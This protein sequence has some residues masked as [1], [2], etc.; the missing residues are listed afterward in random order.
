M[1]SISAII[2]TSITILAYLT[3]YFY[4]SVNLP[5][6]DDLLLI[7]FVEF[8]SREAIGTTALVRDLFSAF[9]D[10]KPVIPRLIS[11]TEYLI[12]GHLNFRFYIVLIS[13]NI[14]FIFYFLYLQFE[15]TGLKFYYFLP[16]PFLFLQPLYH[17]VS[18]WAL[19]GLQ[20]T[21]VTVF[22]ILA[23]LLAS[24]RKKYSLLGSVICC[25]LATFTHGNGILTF[26]AM[27]FFY[28]CFQDFRKAIGMAT[29]MFVAVIT[30]LW[31]YE[32]GQANSVTLDITSLISYQL[33]FVGSSMAI[34][35]NATTP[36]IV[37][38]GITLLFMAYLV[39]KI[40]GN[41][42][43]KPFVLKPGTMELLSLF[44]FIFISGTVVAIFRSWTGITIASRFQLYASLSIV[45]FYILLLNYYPFFQKRFILY[46]IT[47]FS[48][49]YWG[50]SY[51]RYADVVARKR[52][53]YIADVY[54]WR[55]NRTL[56]SID[57]TLVHNVD[58]FLRDAY[59]SGIF[60]LPEPVTTK[61]Q[62]DS[63]F[64]A[65]RHT[66][67]K[68]DIYKEDWTFILPESRSKDDSL[69]Y[70]HLSSTSLPK[71]LGILEDRFLV[72]R[73]MA[74]DSIFLMAANPKKAARMQIIKSGSYY[75]HGF[76]A[77]VRNNDLSSGQYEL[78]LM[79]ISRQGIKK[80]NKLERAL[81]VSDGYLSLF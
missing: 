51:Y 5:Y 61:H 49:L 65:N 72:L 11:L 3:F 79:T 2:L 37:F 46:G 47:L 6:Q 35:N 39:F 33:G 4:F 52:T 8:F 9:N 27:L 19:T 20:H 81:N 1:K 60:R 40:A 25:F 53:T 41:Y 73:N 77:L 56:L 44:A 14:L 48:I 64:T 57:H 58:F 28:L 80:F 38:G 21:F 43:H 12:H 54:N 7:Q 66:A 30:Y 31:G 18:G 76:H 59:E 29:M 45:I 13:V 15:K 10:H 67:I 62:L 71:E 74:N 24:S 42:F 78:G 63:S 68:S 17:D 69:T 70:F 50:Y 23:I 16:V 32:T 22:L 36:S 75:K 55:Y 26:P 34:W